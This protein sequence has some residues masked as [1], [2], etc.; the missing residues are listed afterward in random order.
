MGWYGA[1]HS[2][3]GVGFRWMQDAAEI[4][5]PLARTGD[6]IVR[7]SALPF[8]ADTAAHHL[9]IAVN[10]VSLPAQRMSDAWASY[11]WTVPA[12]AWTAGFNQLLIRSSAATSPA[13]LHLSSDTRRL[14]VAVRDVSLTLQP[15]AR[16]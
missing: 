4:L 8:S 15:E 1:E 7:V 9:S 13:T 2:P 6:I 11:E 10:G 16:R 5:V 14:G 12:S 3:Q